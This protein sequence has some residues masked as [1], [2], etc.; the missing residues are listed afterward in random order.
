MFGWLGTGEGDEVPDRA[1]LLNQLHEAELTLAQVAQLKE[2]LRELREFYHMNPPRGWRIVPAEI[3]SRDPLTWNRGFLINR[4]SEHGLRVGNGVLSGERIIGR[5]T[6]CHGQ[7]ATV[8]TVAAQGCR[9]SVTIEAEGITG[10]L[11]GEGVTSWRG[12]PRCAVHFLP[13]DIEIHAGDL[14]WTSGLSDSIPGGLIVG[15]VRDADG[16]PELAIVDSSYAKVQVEPLAEFDAVR[17]VG[18]ICEERN[19]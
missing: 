2:E 19:P 10:L 4:G 16:V 8:T 1:E 12:A 15:R 6:E 13:C 3:L 17:Y 11:W 9:I 7:S 14:V 5:I 18:V